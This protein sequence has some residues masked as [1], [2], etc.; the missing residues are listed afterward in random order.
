MYLQGNNVHHKKFGQGRIIAM[1][2]EKMT[3]LFQ[4]GEKIFPY[5]SAFKSDLEIMDKSKD[6]EI[7]EALHILDQKVEL[8]NKERTRLYCEKV[9]QINADIM[10][11]GKAGKAYERMN[12]AFKCNF[13]DGGCNSERIGYNGVCSFEMIR[14]NILTEKRAWCS[15]PDS[16]CYLYLT[17]DL[18][19]RDLDSRWLSG[20]FGCYE[21]QMLRDWR[22][23]AGVYQ[24]GKLAGK[25][26]RLTKVKPLSLCIL[27]TRDP[28][29]SSEDERYIFAVFL[30]DDAFVGDNIRE[31]CISANAEY[32]IELTPKEAHKMKFWQYHSNG[33]SPEK[34][35]WGH[36]LHRYIDVRESANILFDIARIKR[37]T[38]DED[39]SNRFFNHFCEINGIDPLIL[40][41]R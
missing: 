36:G 4:A 18:T 11:N 29:P 23:F 16:D 15:N 10:K 1:N 32:R 26:M 38:A 35:A 20:G 31:G 21:S 8:E 12:I 7:K 34:A 25:P 6:K 27:T 33:N 28:Y 13:C 9:K 14:N 30:V 39:L 40:R 19:R 41:D 3:I 22:A 37:G 17:G 5:P 2:N 24:T